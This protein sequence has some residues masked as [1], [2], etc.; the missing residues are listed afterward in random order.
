LVLAIGMKN[1]YSDHFWPDVMTTAQGRA[2]LIEGIATEEVDVVV[3]VTF[4]SCNGLLLVDVFGLVALHQ[5]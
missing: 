3:G 4:I 2:S 5:L 1:P